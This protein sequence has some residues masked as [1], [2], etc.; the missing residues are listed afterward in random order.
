MKTEKKANAKYEYFINNTK[1]GMP[2][3]LTN[4]YF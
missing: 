1:I 3:S 4:N 2:E